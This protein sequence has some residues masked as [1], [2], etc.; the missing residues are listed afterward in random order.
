M[1]GLRSAILPGQ[2][3]LLSRAFEHAIKGLS[4]AEGIP[5]IKACLADK[6]LVLVASGESDHVR[7][8]DV[9]LVTMRECLRDCIGCRQGH[10]GRDALA[11]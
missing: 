10:G 7:L 3:H 6:V 5:A 2:F 8:G 9:A 4:N 1:A 11:N